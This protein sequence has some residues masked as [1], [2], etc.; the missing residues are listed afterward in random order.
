MSGARP[1]TAEE[2]PAHVADGALAPCPAAFVA[3]LVQA[4]G[5][6]DAARVLDKLRTPRRVGLWV[7]P[8]RIGTRDGVQEG[9]LPNAA[10]ID[11]ALAA[12]PVAVAAIPGLA[13]A[14]VMPAAAR[15]ALLASQ[16]AHDGAVW[17]QNP[18]S[19]LPVLALAPQPGQEVLDLAAAPGM[20]TL[21]IAALMA[22]C[23]RIAAVEAIKPRFFKLRDVLQRGGVTIAQTYLADGRMIGRKTPARFDRVLLDAPCSSEARFR[24]DVPASMQ[25]WSEHKVR[26]CAHKQRGLLWS[27]FLALKPGGRMVYSTCS[28]A[29]EENEGSIAWLLTRAAGQARLVPWSAPAGDTRAG[30]T[31]WRNAVWSAQLSL[32]VRV[33]PDGLFGGFFIA[34]I[35]KGL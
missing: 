24:R 35:E 16:A 3:R 15:A 32:C 20:K 1:L 18:S 28:F 10:T 4:L 30:V 29:V 27:A 31:R 11:A 34:V 19:V 7:N 6:V 14:F 5:D 33:L 26:E 25:H 23:G 13:G 2:P 21:H 22:N 9:V 8:L 12:L 17:L